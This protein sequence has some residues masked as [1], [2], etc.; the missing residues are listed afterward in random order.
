MLC[1]RR[2]VANVFTFAQ[3]TGGLQEFD[4]Y[5]R[6]YEYNNGFAD[7]SEWDGVFESLQRTSQSVVSQTQVSEAVDQSGSSESQKLMTDDFGEASPSSQF[8]SGLHYAPS[9]DIAPPDPEL[10]SEMLE[11]LSIFQ[12]VHDNKSAI[13]T[14][15]LL[16]KCIYMCE[17]IMERYHRLPQV[18]AM[19]EQA[20]T[21][22]LMFENG[23]GSSLSRSNALWNI[24]T[25]NSA[26]SGLRSFRNNLL[27]DVKEA[28]DRVDRDEKES[29]KVLT[30]S[31]LPMLFE[32]L[33][34]LSLEIFPTLVFSAICFAMSFEGAAVAVREVTMVVMIDFRFVLQVYLR[35]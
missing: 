33:Q 34:K 16:K 17:R 25:E 7:F 26:S 8:Q 15:S 22:L 13:D 10:R 6:L 19:H 4:D 31:N 28:L 11:L 12:V 20:K 30:Y 3:G 5:G 29:F 27:A 14:R 1:E 2:S 23:G 9:P 32:S 18:V 35:K 21:L 24:S